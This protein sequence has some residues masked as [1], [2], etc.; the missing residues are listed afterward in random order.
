MKYRTLGRSGVKVSP[1]GLGTDN[2]ANP[3]SK[4]ESIQI[5]DRALDAGINFI[6][7]SN[8]Y[9]KGESERI[10]GAA[11][12]D[13]GLRNQVLVATK[14]HYPVGPGPN[15]QGNSRL[16]L[17]KACE[18]S[19]RRLKTDHI[20]LY[21]LHR[22][23]FDIPVEETLSALTDLVRQGKVRYIGSSTAPAWKI[24]ECVM[25]SELKNLA[26]FISEQAPYNLLDRRIENEVV[27]MCQ[28]N[29]LGIIAWS[30]LAMGVLAGRYSD[31]KDFPKGSRAKLRKGI[32][33]ERVTEAGI[34]MAK[35][36]M[37][38]A[39]DRGLSAAQLA[40]LWV[41][42]QLGITLPLLGPRT[43]DQLE[44]FLPV[45]EMEL[46]ASTREACDALVPP[47]SA[48]ANFHNSAPWMKMRLRW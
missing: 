36:F 9:A 26:S 40:V 10:I 17:M 12:A 14:A 44:H 6:D 1:L 13:N 32:Y 2:F 34:E 47:G 23:S 30:P 27:P 24:M 18:D 19:L 38:L 48:A 31:A 11:L 35:K 7:T 4:K 46:D 42:D 3:T 43:L 41:K 15:D 16:H 25:V 20:D 8:S 39:E 22:P 28:A 21:Q 37:P 45:M 5:I 33:S 29:N